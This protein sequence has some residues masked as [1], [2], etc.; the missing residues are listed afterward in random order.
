MSEFDVI[1]GI[2]W[3]TKY[4]AILDCV[5]NSI[6]FMTPGRLS[7]KFQCK[8]TSDEFLTTCLYAIE[9]TEVMNTL[10]D[11][12]IVQDF[13]DVL[14]DISELPPKKEIDFCIELVFGTLPIS[15][16]PYRMAPIEMLELKN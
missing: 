12:L 5:S 7:F 2:D 11:I 8:P 1:L 3:L 6:T 14:R 16:T 9:S 10:A 13:D 4:G 15:K